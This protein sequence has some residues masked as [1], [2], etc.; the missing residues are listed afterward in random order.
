M[1]TKINSGRADRDGAV[2]RSIRFRTNLPPEGGGDRFLHHR[3]LCDPFEYC[4]NLFEIAKFR[5]RRGG[6]TWERPDLLLDCFLRIG[7]SQ[8]DVDGYERSDLD[9][10]R[11][12]RAGAYVSATICQPPAPTD[13]PSVG[14]SQFPQPS[15]SQR[16]RRIFSR[17]PITRSWLKVE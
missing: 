16:S 12:S 11:H 5:D 3:L 6:F 9:L 2:V 7:C 17:W 1:V 10:D 15:Q 4:V 13:G 14:P 8:R